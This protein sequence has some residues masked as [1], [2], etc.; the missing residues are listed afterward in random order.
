VLRQKLS[1]F[2]LI[3]STEYRSPIASE[4]TAIRRST[5]VFIII[6]YQQQQETLNDCG[7]IFCSSI[8]IT[9]AASV[10]CLPAASPNFL[11][12]SLIP[13]IWHLTGGVLEIM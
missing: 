5:N 8:D 11:V 3:S 13:S 2:Y 9:F 6:Y 1:R 12:S 10:L 4:A 7:T